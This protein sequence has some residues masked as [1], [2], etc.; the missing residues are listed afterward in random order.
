LN[1]VGFF[2]DLGLPLTVKEFYEM[3]LENQGVVTK[4]KLKL[5][6]LNKA[7]EVQAFYHKFNKPN[8]P[9]LVSSINEY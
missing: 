2:P 6:S 8:F 9:K 1:F 3:F 4:K 7:T 5:K